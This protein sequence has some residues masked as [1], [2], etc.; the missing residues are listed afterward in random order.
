MDVEQ[1]T[2]M[3]L[4]SWGLWLAMLSVFAKTRLGYVLLYY[5]LL[6]MILFV[7]VSEYK[8]LMPY[9]NGIL[10]IRD[11]NTKYKIDTVASAS[12][13]GTTATSTN[14]QSKNTASIA[15]TAQSTLDTSTVPVT[16]A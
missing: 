3:F 4:V 6:L 14:P 12:T 10:S 8:Q 1:A 15:Q 7:L 13:T 11:F 5:S 2:F 16:I 9:I